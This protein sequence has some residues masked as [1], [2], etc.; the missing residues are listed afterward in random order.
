MKIAFVGKEEIGQACYHTHLFMAKN[1]LSH[2]LLPDDQ[3]LVANKVSDQDTLNF[4]ISKTG[5]APLAVLPYLNSLKKRRQHG[6]A[7]SSGQIDET[8]RLALARIMA[9]AENP[10]ISETKRMAMLHHL[11]EKLAQ[12]DWVKSGYGDVSNQWDAHPLQEAM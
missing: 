6:G 9:A 11:H 5:V 8:L 1:I 3:W 2:T 4:V 7:I 10:A 12:Q